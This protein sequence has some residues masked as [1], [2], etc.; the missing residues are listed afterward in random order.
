MA[1]IQSCAIL[2]NNARLANDPQ[3]PDEVENITQLLT[4]ELVNIEDAIQPEHNNYGLRN[5]LLSEHF[6]PM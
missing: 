1:V 6:G 5:A 2:H 3:P 4:N